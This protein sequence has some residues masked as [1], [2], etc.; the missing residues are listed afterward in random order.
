MADKEKAEKDKVAVK[1]RITDMNEELLKD[2]T[3]SILD[4][5]KKF[6]NEREIAYHIKRE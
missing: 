5:F 4:S 3:N 1:V 2:S 6:T